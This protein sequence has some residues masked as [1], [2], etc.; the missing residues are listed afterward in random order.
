MEGLCPECSRFGFSVPLLTVKSASGSINGICSSKRCLYPFS[1][2]SD[3]QLSHD[4][5]SEETQ[6]VRGFLDEIFGMDVK[7]EKDGKDS[8][9]SVN[10]PHTC[11]DYVPTSSSV[12]FNLTPPDICDSSP[13][14][15]LFQNSYMLPRYL[16]DDM[17]RIISED[18]PFSQHSQFQTTNSL[19][20]S[21]KFNRS[22][23]SGI[24]ISSRS[25]KLS[26]LSYSEHVAQ[27]ISDQTDTISTSKSVSRSSVP[28]SKTKSIPHVDQMIKLQEQRMHLR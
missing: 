18:L 25:S 24:S 21:E 17:K 28:V 6:S 11:T 9:E 1:E 27:R 3:L 23:D 19:C 10:F 13:V 8:S 7:N 22:S 26:T 5:G 12:A 4:H 2:Y 20:L 15:A 14:D 16:A